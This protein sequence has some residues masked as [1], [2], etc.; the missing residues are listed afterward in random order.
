MH[1]LVWQILKDFLL[2]SYHN[3]RVH[4]LLPRNFPLRLNFCQSFL[5]NL[6][7]NPVFGAM[8]LFTDETNF[9]KNA[10]RNFCNQH[11]WAEDNSHAITEH[12]YQEQFSVN[13]WAGIIGDHLIG[14]FLPPRRLNGENY[15]RFLE[16][17]LPE[18]LEE[19][20]VLLRCQMRLMHDGAL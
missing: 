5:Q 15:C 16:D 14:P 12:N 7:E 9:S 2:Y 3:Q 6:A 4:A 11:F 1:V 20:P 8:A 18:L 19:I 17:N 13:V 10:I